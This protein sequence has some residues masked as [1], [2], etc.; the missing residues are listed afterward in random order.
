MSA[1]ALYE[2]WVNHRRLDPVVHEF[3]YPIFMPYLDL[4]ELPRVLDRLPG[5]S[6]RRPAAAW[7]RRSDQLGPAELPLDRAVR[8]RVA[9]QTGSRPQGPVRTLTNLRYFGHCFNPVTFHFCFGTDGERPEAVLADVSNT[10]WGESHAYVIGGAPG[11]EPVISGRIEK[12]FHV[13]PLM[14]M[15][16]VYDWRTSI[17]GERLEVHIE[18]RRE[19]RLAFDATLSLRR[20]EL[21]RANATRMLLRYPAMTAQVVAKIYW[22]ALRLRLKG[23]PWH[24]HPE[25]S[26]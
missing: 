17:P 5:W 20:R 9:G 1:S 6:A 16:H 14:G 4:A 23:A 19:G 7:F 3:R 12:R 25:H 11:E 15:D 21:N 2:G 24:P 18:S 26:R 13:S 22:Q 10:P 8:D